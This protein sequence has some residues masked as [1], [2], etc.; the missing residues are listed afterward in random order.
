V[1]EVGDGWREYVMR[2]VVRGW[3]KRGD[4]RKSE[5]NQIG[6]Q[7]TGGKRRREGG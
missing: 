7:K 3:R 1:D 6:Y 2:E 4:G 5:I